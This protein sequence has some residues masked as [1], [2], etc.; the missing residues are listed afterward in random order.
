M[1]A[2]LHTERSLIAGLLLEEHLV[3]DVVGVLLRGAFWDPPCGAIMEAMWHLQSQG[4]PID[5]V[6]IVDKLKTMGELGETVTAKQ[7]AAISD[8][9]AEPGMVLDLARRMATP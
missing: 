7:L 3:D 1:P 2:D 8:T 5:L 6:M 9:E 4:E